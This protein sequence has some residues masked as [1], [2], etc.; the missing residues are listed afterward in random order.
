MPRIPGATSVPGQPAKT[1][2][3]ESTASP[4]AAAASG[5]GASFEDVVITVNSQASPGV[6]NRSSSSTVTDLFQ[7]NSTQQATGS[8][9]VL[10]PQGHIVTN[11]H[12]VAG[13][14]KLGVTFSDGSTAEA[15]VVGTDPSNDLA[16]IK[17]DVPAGSLH[18]LKLGDSSTLRVGQ[19]A[20]AIGSPFRLQGTVTLG[21]VSSLGRDLQGTN[22]R[23]IG[24]IIQTDAAVNPGN[25]GGPLLNSSGEVIGVNSAIFSP[26]GGNVGI[27]FA[28]PVNTVKRWVPDLITQGRAR[29]PYLGITGQ[30]LDPQLAKSL[31]IS[32][33]QGVLLA[34]VASGTPAATAGLRGGDRQT[35]VGNVRVVTGGDIITAIN[36]SKVKAIEE[37]TYYLDAQTSVGD[38]VTL[39][40]VRGNDTLTVSVT[41]A[42]RPAGT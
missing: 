31:A 30:T 20:I 13:A 24:G 17:V 18:P 22:G 38:K 15:S 5:A 14:S 34:Q 29:H 40:V 39:T 3:S 35:R 10:D 25:S 32:V 16:V 37:L 4:A 12:V 8:G 23:V 28:I 33:Q 1:S 41:L 6:V 9:F 26:S 27:G 11:D 7:Q 21:V 19:L 36:G 2:A 42:E